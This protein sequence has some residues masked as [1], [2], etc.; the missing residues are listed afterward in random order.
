MP[1][2]S[3]LLVVLNQAAKDNRR[4]V[5][6]RD[7]GAD[8]ARRDRRHVIAA[9]VHI[10]AGH[11]TVDLLENIERDFL[12]RVDQGND[13]KLKRDFFVFDVRRDGSR[14]VY[15][16]GGDGRIVERSD[17]NRNFLA[18][19]DD[20]FLVVARENHWSRNDLEFP[21]RL[22]R[23]HDRREVIASGDENIGTTRRH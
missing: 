21:S 23:V 7:V 10:S 18:R 14:I 9:D 12:I 15:R 17:R 5:R 3:L 4:S 6:R 1:P 13:F 19:G 16:S 20:R 8:V 22:E 2:I 11:K